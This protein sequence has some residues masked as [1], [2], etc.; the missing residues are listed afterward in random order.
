MADFPPP[1]TLKRPV[2]ELDAYAEHLKPEEDVKRETDD[3]KDSEM[4]D[5]D[6][7][8]EEKPV[9]ESV[10]SLE[11]S[12]ITASSLP[13]GLKTAVENSSEF[14]PAD[15]LPEPVTR[16]PHDIEH[17][18]V[19]PKRAPQLHF[20][21][22]K[23]GIAYDVRMRYH[24]HPI[25]DPRTYIDPHPEDPR[26]TFR[27][28]RAIAAAG[29][30]ED[31]TLQGSEH[32]GELMKKLP[33]RQATEQE[34]RLV[35]TQDMINFIK[36]TAGMRLEEL[37]DETDHGDSIYLNNDSNEAARLSAGGAIEA[38]KGVVEGTVKNAIA[39]IRPPGHHAEPDNPAGFCLFA[40]VSIASRVMLET[41][42]ETV[43][44]IMIF[45]WDVHHGNGTQRAFL[46]DDRVLYVS[47]HRYD[48]ASFYPGTRFGDMRSVGEGKGRGYSVN[49]PWSCGGMGDGDYMTA[50][51]KIVMPIASEFD[52]DLVIVS[53]GFDAADGDPIGGCHV[54]PEGY[55]NMM[56]MLMTLARGKVVVCLEGGYNL[57]AISRSA[58]AITKIL[59]G[60]PPGRPTS[61]L[62]SNEALKV[63]SEVQAVQSEFWQSMGPPVIMFEPEIEVY[64]QQQHA[65]SEKAEQAREGSENDDDEKKRNG[66]Q[67]GGLASSAGILT[68]ATGSGTSRNGTPTPKEDDDFKVLESLM[69]VVRRDE[70][71]AL[72]RHYNFANLPMLRAPPV[73]SELLSTPNVYDDEKVMLVFHGPSLIWAHRD[74]ITGRIRPDESVVAN[75]VLQYIQWA[76][77]SGYGVVDL[78]LSPLESTTPSKLVAYICEN[79]LRF[80][81]AQQIVIVGAGQAYS[82]AV[83][84]SAHRELKDRLSS[85][86]CFVGPE[87]TLRQFPSSSDDRAVK[88]FHD[89]SLIFISQSHS[90]WKKKYPQKKFGR[91]I[92]ADGKN[93]YAVMR[94]KFEESVEYIEAEE[95]DDE[96]DSEESEEESD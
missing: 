78:F 79:T 30:I 3:V 11:A 51:Q 34:L 76:R 68:G 4:K 10:A 14:V 83:Q 1:A 28:Y 70:S 19:V 95:E 36:S 63:L 46:D 8:K 81:K 60:D 48:D 71:H 88:R 80:F 13:D 37:Q 2:S 67:N 38:C 85:I 45:D 56:A 40:N 17:A 5:S 49:I 33:T 23:T 92:K 47:T 87:D 64:N 86:V 20:F 35:H 90:V 7:S 44:K 61:S 69:A 31:E 43:R 65:L 57:D 50:F 32:L 52:P 29:L 74:P 41:Y 84:T 66:R 58:L 59:L 12:G 27:I 82:Y 54:S 42:P 93:L 26:R 15:P 53:A 89:H 18:L 62:A 72:T 24:S 9:L 25:A 73:D 6:R 77:R 16:S 39:V 94:E 22:K 96:E 21:G 55:Q 75:P 91:L